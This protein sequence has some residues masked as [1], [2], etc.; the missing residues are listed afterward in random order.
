MNV[1]DIHHD[2]DRGVV[3]TAPDVKDAVDSCRDAAKISKLHPTSSQDQWETC[4]RS[5]VTED[6]PPENNRT[7]ELVAVQRNGDLLTVPMAANSYVGATACQQVLGVRE[8]VV[9]G[10]RSCHS[11]E[12]STGTAFTGNNWPANPAWADDDAQRLAQL[13][14]DKVT[15]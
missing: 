14:L 4:A 5:T 6:V 2:G 8:N 10:A 12:D 9:V 11:Q 13:M 7:F 15:T 3:G 1:T